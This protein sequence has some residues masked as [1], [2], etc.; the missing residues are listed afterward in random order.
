[1]VRDSGHLLSKMTC[2]PLRIAILKLKCLE[3]CACHE[4][5]R[6]GIR[7]PAST[8]RND[9]RRSRYVEHKKS[10]LFFDSSPTQQIRTELVAD[11]YA[12]VSAVA[13]ISPKVFGSRLSTAKV[14]H[15]HTY[16]GDQ[17]NNRYEYSRWH[18]QISQFRSAEEQLKDVSFV[19]NSEVL[20]V[21]RSEHAEVNDS[22]DGVMVNNIISFP[23]VCFGS[24]VAPLFNL[25]VVWLRVSAD[26]QKLRVWAVWVESSQ[27]SL[28]WFER[29]SSIQ[30][31]LLRHD[32]INHQFIAFVG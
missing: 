8:T 6:R 26:L 31:S 21:R 3:C 9:F 20:E 27:L 7:S 11:V 32:R 19:Q 30:R 22:K 1:M 10:H 25:S 17:P 5:G 29:A 16:I 28:F 13:C 12:G 15:A 24:S 2:W 14:V 4:K 18:G 23:N